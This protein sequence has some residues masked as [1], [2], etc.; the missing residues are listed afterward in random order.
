MAMFLT[1]GSRTANRFLTSIDFTR[2]SFD[3]P[4]TIDFSSGMAPPERP[5]PAPRVTTGALLVLQICNTCL[6]CSMFSGKTTAKG[7]CL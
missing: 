6:T 3:K 5:V 2:L 7:F 4:K 1:P